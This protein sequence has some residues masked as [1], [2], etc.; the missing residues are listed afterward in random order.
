MLEKL[1]KDKVPP[2]R[3]IGRYVHG[4]INLT[5]KELAKVIKL[6]NQK[7]KRKKGLQK[8]QNSV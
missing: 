3:I 6:K 1:L 5:P 2:A 7:E 8:K 4:I